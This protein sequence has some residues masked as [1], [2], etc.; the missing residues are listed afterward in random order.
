MDH[1]QSASKPLLTWEEYCAKYPEPRIP[2][3]FIVE[4]YM[5]DATAEEKAEAIKNLR[6]YAAVVYAIAKRRA[7]EELEQEALLQPKLF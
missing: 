2:G 7:E 1:H 6:E 3:M 4:R 5:P